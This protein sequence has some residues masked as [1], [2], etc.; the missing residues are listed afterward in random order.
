MLIQNKPMSLGGKLRVKIKQLKAE[1]NDHIYALRVKWCC[2][3]QSTINH[4]IKCYLVFWKL[5]NVLHGT[6]QLLIAE[7]LEHKE[8]KDALRKVQSRE[9]TLIEHFVDELPDEDGRAFYERYDWEVPRK[10]LTEDE[11]WNRAESN[12]ED[13]RNCG[14]IP[15]GHEIIDA[16][17]EGRKFLG[18]KSEMVLQHP[19]ENPCYQYYAEILNIKKGGWKISRDY[20]NASILGGDEN[21]N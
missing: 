21:V 2:Y 7:I 4:H 6:E 18:V 14:G 13:A 5:P 19:N 8:T 17:S 12:Y 20:R 10:Y 15:D 1:I 9:E 3:M 11:A 16:R